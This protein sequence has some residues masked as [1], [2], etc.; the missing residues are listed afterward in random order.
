M[1]VPGHVRVVG[2][3]GPLEQRLLERADAARRV[4]ALP[5]Q[6]E[7]Q[8]RGHLVVAAPSGVELGAGGAGE[9]GDPPLDR[10]VDVFVGA[11]RTRT[12]PSAIS[13]PT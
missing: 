6:E 9:L 11:A 4:G 12:L 7:P 2:R 5:P 3:T 8:R 10:G 13:V 1:R